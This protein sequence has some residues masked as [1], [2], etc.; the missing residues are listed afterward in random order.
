[1]TQNINNKAFMDM[2]INEMLTASGNG[3]TDAYNTCI[4]A[5]LADIGNGI[6]NT[7]SNLFTREKK[8]EEAT[9]SPVAVLKLYP[10]EGERARM[11]PAQKRQL[12]GL[13]PSSKKSKLP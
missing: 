1:M 11:S 9:V 7:T 2:S 10:C 3:I 6:S 5:S 8:E 13:P 4:N 12:L